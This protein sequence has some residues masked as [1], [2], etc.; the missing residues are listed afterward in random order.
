MDKDKK[1]LRPLFQDIFTMSLELYLRIEQELFF[2]CFSPA[3]FALAFIKRFYRARESPPP[4][5]DE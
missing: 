3:S 5:T 4:Q 2:L 1:E